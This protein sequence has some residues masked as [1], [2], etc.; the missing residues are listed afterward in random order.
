[1][2][3][4]LLSTFLLIGDW[5]QTRYIATTH[6]KEVNPIL[7]KNPSLST[8][9]LYFGSAII[10]NGTIWKV[11]PKKYKKTYGYT[12]ASYEAM[13]VLQNKVIGIN[14]KF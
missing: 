3:E 9:N 4:L 8:V 2:T 12:I 13:I 10:I 7:G 6:Y 14:V 5:G 1:M 11:L